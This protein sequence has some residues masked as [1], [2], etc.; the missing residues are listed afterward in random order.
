M[1]QEHPADDGAIPERFEFEHKLFR[2]SD[3]SLFRRSTDGTK[4]PLFILTIADSEYAL[5]FEGI[6]AEFGI[7]EDAPDA[8]ML[9]L[10]TEALHYQ[11]VIRPG[12]PVPKEMVTGEASWAI[13]DEHRRIAYQRLNVQLVHWLTGDSNLIT[14]PNQLQQIADDPATRDKVND[15]LAR[16]A[17][18]LGLG[19]DGKEIV[20][21]QIEALA[22]DLAG[23]E[24]LRD[25]LDRIRMIK[26]KVDGLAAAFKDEMSMLDL[27]LPVAQLTKRALT[28]F[29]DEFELL[30]AQT[31]E[32]IAV[33]RNLE[34]QTK[35][36][37]DSRDSLHERLIDWDEMT[38]KFGP[39]RISGN[40]DCGNLLREAYRFLAP[41]FMQVDQWDLNTKPRD[42]ATSTAA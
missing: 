6:L 31:G 10:V 5:P 4:E 7:E 28:E 22:E 25:Y 19:D 36:I 29:E 42:D 2:S 13:T 15:A 14:D 30:D 1:A 33:L 34:A 8:R 38:E 35:F 20:L 39:A 40:D 32:I 23:I 11:R 3:E 27:A 41:R 18:E 37:R 9:E 26:E 16:A 24:A 12:D 17:Q 21:G